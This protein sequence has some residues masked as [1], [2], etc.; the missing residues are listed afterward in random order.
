MQ[1]FLKIPSGMANSVDLD[2]TAPDL[3]LHCLHMSHFGIRNFR[4]F[5]IKN[6][7]VCTMKCHN[8]ELKSTSRGIST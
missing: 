4:I 7:R 6:E 2:Q 5:T 3:G 8:H 1:P